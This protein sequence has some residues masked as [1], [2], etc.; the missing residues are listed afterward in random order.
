[1]IHQALFHLCGELSFVRLNC[2]GSHVLLRPIRPIA[3]TLCDVVGLAHQN[4]VL[5]TLLAGGAAMLLLFAHILASHLE[6]R[7][8]DLIYSVIKAY[9]S[10]KATSIVYQ[11]IAHWAMSYGV[12]FLFRV[13]LYIVLYA[14]Y[15]LR[16]DVVFAL[17]ALLGISFAAAL[18]ADYLANGSGS[19]NVRLAAWTFGVATYTS[20]FWFRYMSG[21]NSAH[22]AFDLDVGTALVRLRPH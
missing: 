4:K 18:L 15:E 19:W 14:A 7:T 21:G 10:E 17:S 1:L 22:K 5:A 2:T 6:S 20:W 13:C 11:S 8:F 12:F 3:Q 9:L 16:R